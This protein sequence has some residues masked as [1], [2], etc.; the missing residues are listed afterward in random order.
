MI[1]Y[2]KSLI[3]SRYKREI[4]NVAKSI[5]QS[6]F[7]FFH[8]DGARI[9]KGEV[10][11]VLFVCKGNICRSAFAEFYLK[12]LG[13]KNLNIESCGLDVDQ[14]VFSPLDAIRI[15]SEFNI[16]LTSNRSK[17]IMD[18][19]AKN[20]DLIVSMEFNHYVRLINMFPNKK[21]N[22]V[23]LRDFAPWPESM[24]CNIYDPFGSS[25]QEFRR[26]F[27]IMQ[28]SLDGLASRIEKSG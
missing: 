9:K 27:K 2:L 1:H 21:S 10:R 6:V 26:C 18:C 16:D 19:S 5:W 28:R 7:Y 13:M 14:G 12:E 3:S 23:L 20:A 11:Y 22:I 17:N 24:M 15:A 25:I 8:R 4:K